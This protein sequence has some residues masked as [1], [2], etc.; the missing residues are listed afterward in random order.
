[1]LFLEVKYINVHLAISGEVHEMQQL[2]LESFTI[3]KDKRL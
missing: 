1:M 2:S 3:I